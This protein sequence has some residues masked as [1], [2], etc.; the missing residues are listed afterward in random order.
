LARIYPSK[1][2]LF[3]EYTV[4]SGSQALAVPLTHWK[5]EWKQDENA[6]IHEDSP[7]YGYVDWLKAHDFISAASAAHMITDAEEGWAYEADIPIGYGLGSSGAFVAALY[8]RYI[9]KEN[10]ATPSSVLGMLAKMEGYFHGSSSGM[11]PMVS[12]SGEAV[13]KDEQGVFQ[14]VHDP[15]WPEGF[16]VYLLDS[17]IE[18]STG[19]LVHI[20]K[21]LLR[22][23]EFKTRVTRELIPVVEHAI[24]FYLSGTG[25]MLEECLSVISQFERE[26][27]SMLIPDPVKDQWDE[28]IEIPGVYVK[29]CGAGGGGYFQVI[30]TS[31]HPSL[32]INRLVSIL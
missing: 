14:S 9:T 32:P 25:S 5:G 24:H 3:G 22:D 11:D 13:Y 29:F 6:V 12:Y 2:L 20:F 7:L 30:S 4:L 19:P 10:A 26:Y 8:D 16:K 17:G 1:L 15:G 21:E 28:L 18:R 31:I 27:F 23:P